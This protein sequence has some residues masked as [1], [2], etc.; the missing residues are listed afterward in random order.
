MISAAVSKQR[1]NKDLKWN[2]PNKLISEGTYKSD[3]WVTSIGFEYS[4]SLVPIV[5][6]PTQ[7]S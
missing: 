2:V 4:Y 6:F 5:P 1:K 3:T 7:K